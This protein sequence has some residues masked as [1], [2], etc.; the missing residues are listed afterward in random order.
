[1]I[2]LYQVTLACAFLGAT[3]LFFAATATVCALWWWA[4]GRWKKCIVETYYIADLQLWARRHAKKRDTT[5]DND[6]G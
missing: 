4:L 5:G 2:P 3:V 1:M 6:N